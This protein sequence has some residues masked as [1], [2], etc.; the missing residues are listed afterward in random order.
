MEIPGS[1]GLTE[2]SKAENTIFPTQAK[3]NRRKIGGKLQFSASS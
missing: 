1:P 2:L 3:G